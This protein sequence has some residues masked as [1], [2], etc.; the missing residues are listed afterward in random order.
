MPRARLA[1]VRIVVNLLAIVG[2]LAI[3]AA[4]ALGVWFWRSSEPA[5]STPTPP[6]T[7]PSASASPPATE[8]PQGDEVPDASRPPEDIGAGEI[9]AAGSR[10]ESARVETESGALE[11]VVITAAGLTAGQEAAHAGS[12]E[13]TA[14]VPFA[15]VEAQVG[16]GIRLT[17]A[18]D[19][20][21]RATAPFTVLGRSLDVSGTGAVRADGDH[22]VVT[23]QAL[24][25][26]GP[27][28]IGQAVGAAARAAITVRE[29][30]PGLPTG[31]ALTEVQVRDDGFHVKL[32]GER[33]TLTPR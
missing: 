18:G 2:A 28:V 33:V 9:W 19:G 27:E 3:C 10:L 14:R 15:T 31:L 29:P 4:V 7:P 24:D 30:V 1:I 16:N 20:R 8:T 11:N 25:L 23:P 26:P 6:P 22:I 21:V 32:H 13:V 17:H 12:V 5:A